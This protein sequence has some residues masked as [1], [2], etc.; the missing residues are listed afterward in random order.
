MRVYREMRFS[1]SGVS[2]IFWPA[3]QTA[4]RR[5]SQRVSI[6]CIANIIIVYNQFEMN[7]GSNN[8]GNGQ[9]ANMEESFR[10]FSMMNQTPDNMPLPSP[11]VQVMRGR[12]NSMNSSFVS[13]MRLITSPPFNDS[14]KNLL[15]EYHLKPA[16]KQQF[17][18]FS[19]D[20]QYEPV[21]E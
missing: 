18:K 7:W 11:F 1:G 6:C 12:L 21:D 9:P 3:R 14:D 8:I 19:L 5:I 10:V 4:S 13:P 15:Y 17:E 16:D 2:V 20:A